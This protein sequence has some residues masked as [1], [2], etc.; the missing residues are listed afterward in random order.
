MA[1]HAWQLEPQL[2][3]VA[4][5]DLLDRLQGATGFGRHDVDT[6]WG[7]LQVGDLYQIGAIEK[8]PVHLPSQ[9]RPVGGAVDLTTRYGQHDD[10]S[11]LRDFLDNREVILPGEVDRLNAGPIVPIDPPIVS[12]KRGV[13]LDGGLDDFFSSINTQ[14]LAADRRAFDS[15][16]DPISNRQAADVRSTRD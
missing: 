12:G 9:G 13:L 2:P 16:H 4:A 5:R 7:S 14:P 11:V 10:A 3:A 8:H 6:M 1:E 15:K